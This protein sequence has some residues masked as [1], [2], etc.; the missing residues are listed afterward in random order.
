MILSENFLACPTCRGA[1]ERLLGGLQ[2]VGTGRFF[3]ITEGIVH[4]M[5][6]ASPPA[7]FDTRHETMARSSSDPAARL[8]FYDQ[9]G[10]LLRRLLRDAKVILDVGCGPTLQY[11]RPPGSVVLGLDP[12]YESLRQ[13]HDVDIRL[14][15]SAVRLPVPTASL[16]AVVCFYSLH[17][18]VDE[19]V[20]QTATLV[21]RALVECARVLRPGGTLLVFEV[22]PWWPAWVAQLVGWGLARRVLKESLNVF[23][24]R[25]GELQGLAPQILGPVEYRTFKVDPWRTVP[26]GF[27]VPWLRLPR[28]LY[29]FSL[30]L[31]RWIKAP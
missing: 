7:Y 19:T 27:S 15:G 6:P 28:G 2:C 16:D 25:R 5:P 24:W 31:Y 18:L 21:A 22:T 29:P 13:N 11:D 26:V 3:P 23:F 12:S 8:A 10:H 17:H 4:V 9:Q 1:V 14:W 30:S 20:A